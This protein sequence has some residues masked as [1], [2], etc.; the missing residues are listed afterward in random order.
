MTV[1]K[2]NLPGMVD[3]KYF[4]CT[5]LNIIKMSLSLKRDTCAHLACNN[6]Q[7]K[8]LLDKTIKYVDSFFLN[9]KRISDIW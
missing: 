1:L 3:F 8:K 9:F 4:D 5:F 6:L 2:D 7:V